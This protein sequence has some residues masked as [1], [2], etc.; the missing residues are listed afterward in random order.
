MAFPGDQRDATRRE[1][2]RAGA[3]GALALSAGGTLLSACGSETQQPD[4]GTLS[5]GPEAGGT[6]VRGG[7]LRVGL[8]Q[9][10]GS[11]ETISVPQTYVLPDYA[12][13]QN[14]YDP[15]FFPVSGGK[16]EPALATEAIPNA[17]ATEWT[18]RL[19][20]G[21]TWHD[22]K[23][24]TADDVVYTIKS[25]WASKDNYATTMVAAVIDFD[26]VRKVDN[27]TVR[28]PLRMPIAQFS[29][30]T[31][32]SNLYVVPDGTK[33]F[34]KAPGTGPFKLES[35][36]PGKQSVFSRNENYWIE[37]QPYIDRLIMDSSFTSETAR[38]NAL[39]G[40]QLDVVPTVPQG[41]ARANASKVVLGNQHGPGA[42]SMGMAIDEKPFTDKRVREAIKLLI[43][44]QAFVDDIYSGY[45]TVG[46]DLLGNTY[47]YF[48]EDLT[49]EQDTEKA[50]SLIKASGVDRAS[51][52]LY[53]A[54]T[55]PGQNAFATLF[56]Q[57]AKAAGLDV[58]VTTV[59]PSIYYTAA[60]P[61]GGVVARA[62]STDAFIGNIQSIP[63]I[64]MSLFG[65]DYFNSTHWP[66]TPN[67]LIFD[68]LGEMDEAAAKDKWRAAQ[69]QQFDEGGYVVP[70][71]MNWV[72]AY[73]DNIRGLQTTNAG[74]VD[75]YAFRTGWLAQS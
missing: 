37:G 52:T 49:R 66:K 41:L 16:V 30:L 38:L 32:M 2:L 20:D 4:A 47:E 44:R 56:K 22:G 39:L 71:F 12:R 31:N 23:S 10:G 14:L 1:F 40:G 24:F 50:A 59:D 25:S 54:D 46:N 9:P 51:V 3:G 8:G 75:N 48:A 60:A 65:S 58:R 28:V 43:D 63:I 73:S 69:Q 34:G 29:Y 68:A 33:D 45:A 61:G 53:T 55:A 18:I 36:N 11:A 74:P 62:F 64:Y 27:L 17:D 15:L 57:Q 6:P 13:S 5:K 72:D 35:F 67:K 42:I 7:T 70:A 21:V 19:R 26:G